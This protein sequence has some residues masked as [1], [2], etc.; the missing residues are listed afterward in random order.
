MKK[1][2]VSLGIITT[3]AVQAQD[4]KEQ[5]AIKNLCG[6]YEVE[7]MYAETFSENPVYKLSKPYNAHGLEWVE[8]VEISDKKLVL[9]HLLQISDTMIIKHWRE[10]WEY[11]KAG[12]WK[13]DKQAAWKYEAT[14]KQ[15]GQWTQTVWEVD[16]APR[17]QGT[18]HW[19]SNNHKY[20][21]EN[22]TDAPLP[23]REYSTRNDYNVL[24]RTNR[25]IVTDTAWTHEQDNL[26]V[27]RTDGAA[28]K[29]IA[30]EKGYNIYT[31]V[32]DS[33]C[34]AAAA[35]WKQHGVFWNTVRQSW[36]EVLKEKKLVRL[37]PKVNGQSMSQQL[38]SLEK[39]Q[40]ADKAQLKAKAVA[41]LQQF[42]ETRSSETALSQK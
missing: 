1:L 30:Q 26:K 23:R 7:F 3:L 6:C 21:W 36:D 19:V 12:L 9:Q 2:L 41:V 8:P 16:D 28:D 37:L 40:V 29:A 13:F 25:I 14:P 24:Q 39:E 4:K 18:S 5:Q 17:Y 33:R 42:T 10:D 27:L 11:E 15:Q 32:S 22:T 35:W 31:K 34:A 20:Y 38:A